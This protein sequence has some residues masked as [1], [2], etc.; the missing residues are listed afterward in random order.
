MAG[1]RRALPSTSSDSENT[2]R[3]S[4][5][6]SAIDQWEVQ[7]S[8]FVCNSSCTNSRTHPSLSPIPKHR[9]GTWISAAAA[10]LKLEYRRSSDGACDAVIVVSIPHHVLVSAKITSVELAEEHYVTKMNF[11]WPQVSCISG[12]PARGSRSVFL[13]YKDGVGQAS[14]CLSTL[15][16]MCDFMQKFALRFSAIH[17]SEAFMAL[18]KEI[19]ERVKTELLS[20]PV[21]E[22]NI[23]SKHEKWKASKVNSS[24]V[25]LLSSKLNQAKDSE[26][27]E[28]I[29]DNEAAE[30]VPVLPSSFSQLMKNCCPAV[31]EEKPKELQGDPKIQF[32][33]YL[34][35]TSFTDLLATV[36][37]VI[38]VLEGD[39]AL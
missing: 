22:S 10:S 2:P 27:L 33:K 28:R 26:S 8:R 31:S 17:D 30:A 13:S 14:I 25:M 38:A 23:S 15:I 24:Q 16:E 21:F 6:S 12:F 37:D 9:A 39:M 7:Y 20:G 11:S 4:Q 35:G 18:V 36:E 32:M 34:E 1:Q 29:V 5:I 3:K 19:M